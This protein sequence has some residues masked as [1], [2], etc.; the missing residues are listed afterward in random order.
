MEIPNKLFEETKK[1]EKEEIKEGDSSQQQFGKID[2][3][4]I[5]VARGDFFKP[6]LIES[7]FKAMEED[8]LAQLEQFQ[9]EQLLP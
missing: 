6:A 2:D 8:D 4:R 7:M 5:F 3:D 9:L 1:E